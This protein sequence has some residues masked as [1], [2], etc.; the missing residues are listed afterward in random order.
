MSATEN[1]QKE[2]VQKKYRG[3]AN[4]FEKKELKKYI[5]NYL[6]F[7]G[8]IEI[9]IFLIC[10]LSQ[11]E[12]IDIPFPW[13][14]YFFI[15][16]ATPICITFLLG[17][18]TKSFNEFI[19]D[20]KKKTEDTRALST[21]VFEFQQPKSRFFFFMHMLKKPPLMLSL[22][23]LLV[24]SSL[25]YHMDTIL[26]YAGQTSEK[27]VQYILLGLTGIFCL[28]SIVG[29]FMLLMKYRLHKK[30]ID[31]Q[32]QFKKDVLNQTGLIILDN[33]NV[34]NKQGEIIDSNSHQDMP[35]EMISDEKKG[36][37]GQH[38]IRKGI[39]LEP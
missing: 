7:L 5:V 25:L 19:F 18:I 38:L 21:D 20:D 3:I 2:K 4:L 26:L 27:L 9:I 29:I 14:Q 32:Y 10:F 31:L 17:V 35:V 12:P 13:R 16:F 6:V 37:W 24:F 11:L 34:M 36:S 23:G 30:N 22:I 8:V 1:A 15:A 33:N 39:G 28:A